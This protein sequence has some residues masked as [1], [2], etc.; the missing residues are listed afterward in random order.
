MSTTTTI[1]YKSQRIA[2]AYFA[3]AL[4][5]FALQI[6]VGLWVAL[7]YVVTVPQGIVDAFPFSTARAIHTNLLVLWLLLGF[8]G[9][10]F[11]LVPEEAERE[12]AWPR[13]AIVQL[14]ALAATGVTAIVG[15]LFG[16]IQ[17][18]P[19]LEIP[20]PLD[21]VVVAAALLFLAN[22]GVTLWRARRWN[23]VQGTLVGGLVFL[24][25]MYLFGMPF[26]RNLA[27]DW[28]YWWWV[29]HLWVEGAWEL[30]TAAMVAF[31]MI[32][33]TGV[34][35]RIVERWLY[36]ELGLFLFTGLAG[37]GHHYY[38]LGAPRAWLW[39]GGAFSALEPLPI[40]LMLWDTW[41]ATKDGDG[42][43][44]PRLT[45]LYVGAMAVLHFVGA[46]LFG[47][48][49]TLPQINYYTHGSQVT[50]SHG[51][52]SFFGAYALLNLAFFYFAIPRLKG[53]PGARYDARLG[54]W[55]FWLTTLGVVGMSLAFGVAGVLQTY[56]ERV[57]GE[58]F[59]V[60]QQ[61]MR[62]WM[63]VVFLHGLVVLAGVVATVTH[64]L[65]LK[66][67][68]AAAVVPLPAAPPAPAVRT[69]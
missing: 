20:T 29:I 59:M 30:V 47:F 45:W 23:A 33:L 21:F 4:V 65:T 25:L 41:R 52:L 18:R 53:L 61:P 67:E 12:L 36:V 57:R 6:V 68:R 64:L 43:L 69:A 15:F 31:M 32:K 7:Q 66:P 46:G 48:A 58:P 28:Y 11:Y 55:G 35:R 1:A 51:H 5:L 17:G 26:Y 39:I 9:A 22:V 50:T 49:H 56:L 8:M 38:W 54:Y 16:W 27:V 37:T 14:V 19:L 42:T 3:L 63:L 24:A 2:Y 40:L 44:R 62:F 10:T 60:A 13:L 34:D